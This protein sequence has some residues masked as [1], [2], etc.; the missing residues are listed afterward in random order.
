MKK[1]NLAVLT[2][3]LFALPA[4]AGIE[5]IE[6]KGE[7]PER[8]AAI[9]A[10]L[11]SA[12]QQVVGV[13]IAS[14][15]TSSNHAKQTNDGFTF[16]NKN[17]NTV[18]F[19]TAGSATYRI[20]SE[21][22]EGV[23]CAVRIRASVEYDDDMMRQKNLKGMNGNRRTLAIEP[24]SG[25]AQARALTRAVEDR[26]V[27][28]RL[29]KVVADRTLPGV[30]YVLRGHVLTAN[31]TKKTVDNRHT[32][33][34]TGET[35]GEVNVTYSSQVVVEYQLLDVVN[36]QVKWSAKVPTSSSR[37]NLSQLVDITSRK[38]FDQLKD[39]IY[40]IVLFSTSDGHLVLNSGGKT[41]QV[42]ELYNVFSMGEE[43]VD[44]Y[45]KESLGFDESLVGQVKVNKV[46]HKI[47]Y[48][49]LVKGKLE[50]M[51]DLPV[52]RRAAPKKASQ[53]PQH[54]TGT[55]AQPVRQRTSGVVF[56]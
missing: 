14:E 3:L 52:V 9:N 18:R 34:L 47:A 1:R 49:T 30:D 45:T 46:Q 33:Q 21:N 55:I 36:N 22:C 41:V 16:D 44:P 10:A 42:G 15:N 11:I 54:A 53:A 7:G 20:L 51:Q 43:L 38:V 32:V 27:Q 4:W 8:S 40:P 2:G 56:P 19:G 31:T 5:T 6:V 13:D 29:F 39:N 23:A 12:V 35:V 17:A 26:F 37:N 24:F 48:V 50:D 28:D 25:G